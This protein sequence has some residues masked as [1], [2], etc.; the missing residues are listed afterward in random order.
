L[1]IVYAAMM[2]S[3]MTK[4]LL[5]LLDD[6]TPAGLQQRPIA[7]AEGQTC[8]WIGD[9]FESWALYQFGVLMLEVMERSLV[10]QSSS[11]DS[12]ERAAA[13]GLLV[14]HKAVSSLA[15][16]G[17][18]SFVLVSVADSGVALF[19]LTFVNHEPHL[20]QKFNAAESAFDVAG[21][22]ASGAAIYNVYVVESQFTPFFEEIMPF[23]KF[24]TVKILVTFAYGQLYIFQGLRILDKLFP[25]GFQHFL[26][27]IPGIS[28]L[29]ECNDAQFY[30]FYSALLVFE[31][32]AIAVTHV[33]AWKASEEWYESQE[34]EKSLIQQ[35]DF[36]IYGTSDA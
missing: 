3:C 23:L 33:F 6:T 31:C 12:A 8:S 36:V 21:F 2:L 7:V 17:I 13:N 5:A 19:F 29:I 25:V 24:L 26:R 16:L 4:C 18:L 35:S 28:W 30:V 1:P 10:K 14:A 27:S 32:F 11:L 22:L 20:L 9:L 34:D 15:W